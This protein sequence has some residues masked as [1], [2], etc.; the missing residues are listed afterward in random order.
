MTLL[1]KRLGK[2][3]LADWRPMQTDWPTL[4]YSYGIR[5]YSRMNAYGMLSSP[6]FGDQNR[7]PASLGLIIFK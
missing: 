6:A 4:R 1:R 7:N 5:K 3:L 2:R